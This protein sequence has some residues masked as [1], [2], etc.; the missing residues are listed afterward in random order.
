VTAEPETHVVLLTPEG[1]GAVATL[2]VA[3]P[4][5]TLLV[6]GLFHSASRRPLAAQPL[7][8]ILY[9]RWL[10]PNSGEEVIVCRHGNEHVEIHCHGGAAAARAIIDALVARGCRAVDWRQWMRA[11]SGE[12]IA[13]EARI[14][15]ARAPTRRTAAILWEQHQGALCAA[16]DDV[17]GR[18]G[19]K[20]APGALC[21]VDE[22]L[23]WADVG[24]HLVEPWRV[25]LAGR[26]NVGKSSLIN[27]LL[28][29]ERAIVHSTPGTTRD[30]VAAATAID[31]WP[32]ELTDTA[33]LHAGVAP[34]ER[35]GMALT[36]ERLAAADLV[37]LVFDCSAPPSADDEALT[38]A[39]P[40]AL[41]VYNKCDL[42]GPESRAGLP[43]ACLL[44]S[45]T[46]GQG[47]VELQQAIVR[48]LVPR[49]P[50][51]GQAVPFLVEQVETL[52]SVRGLLQAGE[53]DA[54]AKLLARMPSR[55]GATC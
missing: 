33:G 10:S 13:A 11:S 45:A 31:G 38:E 43:S 29:Y 34:L 1:R 4:A 2:L 15:L 27:A 6:D 23:A 53:T 37:V 25:V 46:C 9:G 17:S 35:A 52:Q 7:E 55:A 19:A 21:R 40:Q 51:P 8:R 49:D 30:L 26:P 18:L 20:N 24:R 54:A 14:L 48:R 22:L 16:V 39:W 47:I 41:R 3:G 44:T 36:R 32:V 42:A 12:R 50:Q 5:A 28:G